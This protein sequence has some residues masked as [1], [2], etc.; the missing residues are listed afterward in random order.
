MKPLLSIIIPS[1][2]SQEYISDCLNSVLEQTFKD[3]EVIVINDAS[4]DESLKIIEDYKVNYPDIIKGISNP[5]NYGVAR[6]RHEGILVAKGEYMTTLDSDDYYIDE[7]KL[8]KEMELVLT[9]KERTGNDIIAYSNIVYVQG[10]QS[11]IKI[12]GT[13]QNLKEGDVFQD[14]L[15]RTC[16]IPR[17]F[18]MIKQLFFEVGGYDF[19]FP[20]YED[21][22]LK[23]RLAKRYNFYYT[24][25]NGT[26]Y[27]RHEGGLSFCPIPEHIKWMRKVFKKNISL[28]HKSIRKDVRKRFND[29]IGEMIK[30]KN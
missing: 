6:T 25:I 4:T 14:I 30:R 1:Y 11:P 29:F 2:N 16:M 26:A 18:T 7:H 15:S 28:C 5:E 3:L 8:E 27:R 17:D 20:I 13:P 21:W 10:D 24:G 22:D 9:H 12:G 23:I 19:S